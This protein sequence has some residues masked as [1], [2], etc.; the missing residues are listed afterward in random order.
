MRTSKLS[1]R[2]SIF[3]ALWFWLFAGAVFACMILLILKG[4]I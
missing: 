4:L 3:I 1:A 2:Q